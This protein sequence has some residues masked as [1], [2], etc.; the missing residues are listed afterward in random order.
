MSERARTLKLTFLAAP[1]AMGIVA[2]HLLGA[3][4]PDRMA[5]ALAR[6]RYEAH[7]YGR[8]RVFSRRESSYHQFAAQTLEAFIREAA[9]ASLGLR[10]PESSRE[11]IT[12][13]LLE[14]RDD[15]DPPADVLEPGGGLF[16][17]A[18]LEIVIEVGDYGALNT[19]RDA[20]ALRHQM[21][22]ALLHLNAP[23]A[24]WSPW[25]S[26]GLAGGFEG[27]RPGALEASAP[28]PGW[29]LQRLLASPLRD[30]TDREGA[31]AAAEAR[32]LV[33]FLAR[34]PHYAARFSAYFAE[35]RRDGPVG[36]RAF[37]DLLGRPEDVEREWRAWRSS[38]K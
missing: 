19:R 26:E 33:S 5:R 1:L 14:S 24:Q 10:G 16:L 18:T 4:F 7:D 35:E 21:T 23:R 25:L 8:F 15:L 32:S 3:G 38:A 29:T 37:E 11:R 27:A 34:S 22:H 28:P 9:G 6:N 30:F 20:A 2:L 13:R 31:I 12:V 17:P 36:P